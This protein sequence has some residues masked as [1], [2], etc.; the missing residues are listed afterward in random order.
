MGMTTPVSFDGLVT[1]EQAT[2]GFIGRCMLV[3]EPETNPARK[4]GF[5]QPSRKLPDNL[6]MALSQIY[7]PGSAEVDDPMRI[8]YHGEKVQI[9]TTDQAIDML[10]DAA[11]W[12]EE[13]AEKHKGRTGLEAVI[14]R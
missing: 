2:N 11:D 7:S 8:E 5:R 13:F 4:R 3:R 10:E 12:L 9:K 14:R 6:M 1:V